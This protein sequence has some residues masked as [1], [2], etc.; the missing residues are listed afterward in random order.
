MC[1]N[2]VFRGIQDTCWFGCPIVTG[3][4]EYLGA[5]NFQKK[6]GKLTWDNRLF[7]LSWIV[8]LRILRQ[9]ALVWSWRSHIRSQ[10]FVSTVRGS[11]DSDQSRGSKVGP[12]ILIDRYH[13]FCEP[14]NPQLYP[15]SLSN[16][17]EMS[18]SSHHSNTA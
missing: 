15:T 14:F 6:K 8:F 17:R 9:G 10:K 7:S 5:Q 3:A 12:L 13:W 18:L 2:H 4:C 11:S 1:P 16:L